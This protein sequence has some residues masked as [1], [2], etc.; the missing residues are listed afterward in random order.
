MN[1]SAPAA[2]RAGI[3]RAYNQ[4]APRTGAAKGIPAYLPTRQAPGMYQTVNIGGKR[5]VIRK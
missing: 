1:A 2:P 4:P 5:Y 3:Q